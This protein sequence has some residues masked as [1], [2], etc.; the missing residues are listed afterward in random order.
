MTFWLSNCE[1]SM[2]RLDNTQ[3]TVTLQGFKTGLIGE[4]FLLER[5]FFGGGLPGFNIN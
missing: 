1:Q 4:E 5:V 3:D 2:T